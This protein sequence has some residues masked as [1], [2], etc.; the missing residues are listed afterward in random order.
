MFQAQPAGT[1]GVTVSPQGRAEQGLGFPA[2]GSS[3]LRVGTPARG[4]EAEVEAWAQKY[5]QGI[6]AAMLPVILWPAVRKY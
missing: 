6:A 2:R 1:M 5:L 3:W 4:L